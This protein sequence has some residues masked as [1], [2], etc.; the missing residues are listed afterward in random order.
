MKARTALL[1]SARRVLGDELKADGT[2][3]E[4]RKAAILK[5]HPDTKLD[6]VS[7]DYLRARFDAVIE[8]LGDDAIAQQ[9]A[10]TTGGTPAGGKK[11]EKVDSKAARER[12]VERLRNPQTPKTGTDKE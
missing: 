7:G 3:D 9:R 2:D 12:Y 5:A 1:D 10:D 8:N 11:V 4:I 6:G